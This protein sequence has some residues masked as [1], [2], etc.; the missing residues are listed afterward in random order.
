MISPG[1]I[2]N[3]LKRNVAFL[4]TDAAALRCRQRGRALGTSGIISQQ[5]A[6]FSLIWKKTR[7]TFLSPDVNRPDRFMKNWDT[8]KSTVLCYRS[9]N[10]H[11]PKNSPVGWDNFMLLTQ[12]NQYLLLQSLFLF[13]LQRSALFWHS[14]PCRARLINRPERLEIICWKIKYERMWWIIVCY[15][16]KNNRVR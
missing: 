9:S 12:I 14:Y 15:R 3:G 4:D 6:Q 11:F 13:L 2:K 5:L 8:V 16:V 10:S 7:D 1:F